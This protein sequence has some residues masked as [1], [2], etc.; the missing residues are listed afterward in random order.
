MHLWIRALV[1]E[2]KIKIKI[3]EGY[4]KKLK[5]KNSPTHPMFALV[6]MDDPVSRDDVLAHHDSLQQLD[7]SPAIQLFGN[8]ATSQLSEIV[9]RVRRG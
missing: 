1:F 2:K 7:R 3:C 9:C 6:G 5:I 8:L 4:L